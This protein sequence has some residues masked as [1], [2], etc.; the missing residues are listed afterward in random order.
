M[1]PSCRITSRIE[2]H[3]DAPVVFAGFGVTR[4]RSDYDDYAG[5]D[6]TGKVGADAVEWTRA[7]PR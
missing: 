5:L 6:V 1:S 3:L 4:P 7:L 2:V